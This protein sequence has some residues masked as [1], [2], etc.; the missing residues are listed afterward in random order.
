MIGMK[1]LQPL[2]KVLKIFYYQYILFNIMEKLKKKT[3]MSP[4]KLLIILTL[5]L[6]TMLIKI[7]MLSNHLNWV[8]I[9]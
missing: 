4:L 9:L 8:S 7:N 2:E 3:L 5:N 6:H 1:E